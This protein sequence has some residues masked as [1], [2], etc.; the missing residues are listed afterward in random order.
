MVTS[1]PCEATEV[2][3]SNAE[4]ESACA[5]G[6]AEGSQSSKEHRRR[7]SVSCGWPA[8][9]LAGKDLLHTSPAC[10][11]S[12]APGPDSG[13][14]GKSTGRL[15]VTTCLPSSASLVQ[16]AEEQRFNTGSGW[17]FCFPNKQIQTVFNS[18]PASR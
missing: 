1:G 14:A 5:E 17:R 16:L 2:V 15:G 7:G 9:Q 12:W 11:K 10:S 3:T 6:T 8:V 13:K 18:G 4:G